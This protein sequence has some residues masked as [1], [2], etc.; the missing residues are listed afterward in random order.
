MSQKSSLP[1]NLKVMGPTDSSLSKTLAYYL[2]AWLIEY[3][4]KYL[5]MKDV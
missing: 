2:S 5:I 1:T 4:L 3:F